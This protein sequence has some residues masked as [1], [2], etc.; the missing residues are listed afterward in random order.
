MNLGGSN[1]PV[2]KI[3]L[4]VIGFSSRPDEIPQG[5]GKRN[6]TEEKGQSMWKKKNSL[7]AARE[8][9]GLKDRKEI[10]KKKK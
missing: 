6:Q 3:G 10:K 7:I 5:S 8:S 2:K 1:H 4:S 9:L